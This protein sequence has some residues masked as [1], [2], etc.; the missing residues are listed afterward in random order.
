MTPSMFIHTSDFGYNVAL[1]LQELLPDHS[2]VCTSWR[3]D[4]VDS[5][6]SE[7]HDWKIMLPNCTPEFECL[8]EERFGSYHLI[9]SDD[10]HLYG[11]EGY[12]ISFSAA[13]VVKKINEIEA[14]VCRNGKPYNDCLCC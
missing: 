5:V 7:D 2:L 4:L 12:F 13:E 1:A 6:M 10:G 9:F 11:D 3:N 8:A 14:V